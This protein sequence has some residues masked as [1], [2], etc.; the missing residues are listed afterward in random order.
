VCIGSAD[1]DCR[2]VAKVSCVPSLAPP[3]LCLHVCPTNVAGKTTVAVKLASLLLSAEVQSAVPQPAVAPATAD[4]A[5]SPAKVST[6]TSFAAKA[7]STSS[8]PGRS[9]AALVSNAKATA[10][11]PVIAVLSHKNHALDEFLTRVVDGQEAQELVGKVSLL[12]A[13]CAFPTC[14][15]QRG[16]W[17]S[18]GAPPQI[19]CAPDG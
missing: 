6:A 12:N 8:T 1:A 5:L 19:D 10:H 16:L 18:S 13:G 11:R 4:L 14:N 2:P 15:V 7:S 17:P 3:S 9:V